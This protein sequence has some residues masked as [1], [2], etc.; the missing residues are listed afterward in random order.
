MGAKVPD[1]PEPKSDLLDGVVSAFRRRSKAIKHMLLRWEMSL[2]TD[3]SVER[4]NVD[5]FCSHHIRLSVWADG[6]MWVRVCKGDKNGWEL[7][8]SFHLDLNDNDPSTVTARFE[9]THIHAGDQSEVKKLWQS[10]NPQE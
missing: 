4:L 1:W 5:T 10:F 6:Q 9:E 3:D 7:N 8:Y 2:E